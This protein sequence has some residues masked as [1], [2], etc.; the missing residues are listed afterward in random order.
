MAM[1][2]NQETLLAK[3]EREFERRLS[4]TEFHN[5]DTVLQIRSSGAA[6]ITTTLVIS[7]GRVSANTGPLTAAT[8]MRGEATGVENSVTLPLASLNPLV[9]GYQGIRDLARQP[10]TEIGGG[11]HAQRLIEVL[12]PEDHPRGG[13]LPLVWE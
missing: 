7:R 4:L 13:H 12:F 2:L 1:V 5:V 9:T 3:M 6:T 11:E 8:T 10:A